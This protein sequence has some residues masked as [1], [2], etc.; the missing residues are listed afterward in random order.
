[1]NHITKSVKLAI[2][3]ASMLVLATSSAYAAVRPV[4][5]TRTVTA[6]VVTATIPTP[7]V[8]VVVPAG[9]TTPVYLPVTVINTCASGN[10][11]RC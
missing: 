4:V 6:P 7:A 11:S 3:A 10:A 9:T 8:S 2:S 1:M 5:V